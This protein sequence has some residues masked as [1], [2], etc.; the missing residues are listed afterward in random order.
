VWRKLV[1]LAHSP[2]SIIFAL[3]AELTLATAPIRI[4]SGDVLEIPDIVK[5]PHVLEKNRRRGERDG[6]FSNKPESSMYASKRRKAEA[7]RIIA[8]RRIS[9]LF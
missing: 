5:L 9:K 1:V 7:S 8:K 3:H 6:T 2:I 4:I